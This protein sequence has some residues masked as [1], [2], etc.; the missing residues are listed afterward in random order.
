MGALREITS[1]IVTV[2]NTG[3]QFS[4]SIPIDFNYS[5]L[6][7]VK[8]V[9]L[10]DNSLP[11]SKE[12]YLRY[13]IPGDFV[14]ILSLSKSQKDSKI[15]V[16]LSGTLNSLGR[17]MLVGLLD[18]GKLCF[19]K[20]IDLTTVA[21]L[22]KSFSFA[23]SKC[24]V[25]AKPVV[26]IFK[27]GKD[28]VKLIT[29][30]G[31]GSKSYALSILDE[32]LNAKYSKKG[33]FNDVLSYKYMLYAILGIVVL[34]LLFAVLSLSKRKF[35]SVLALF[36]FIS[37]SVAA[38]A[39]LTQNIGVANPITFSEDAP[40]IKFLVNFLNVNNE[41]GQNDNIVFDLSA[42]DNFSATLQKYPG[43][44]IY[45]SLDG[46]NTEALVMQATDPDPTVTVSLP[47]S[48]S[49]GDHEITFRVPD[50]CG[51]AYDYSSFNNAEFGTKDCIFTTP[52]TV[53]QSATFVNLT[54]NPLAVPQGGTTNLTWYLSSDIVSCTA[55]GAW[56]GAKSTNPV[57]TEVSQNLNLAPHSYD[58]RLSC[59]NDKG[60]S[61]TDNV[62]VV[63]YNCGD[64]VCTFGET[65][66]NCATDCGACATDKFLEIYANPRIV[67][68]GNSTEIIWKSLGYK[69]C[70]VTEDNDSINDY[71]T[72]LAK[73][74]TSSPLISDTT[75]TLT[76]TDGSQTD[77]KSVKV[78]V[79]PSW[80]EY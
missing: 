45:A 26:I 61:Y 25:N 64:G 35:L 52:F 2:Q 76:C 7:D 49:L 70:E 30:A 51:S 28:N 42:L 9:I 38:A 77:S 47:H 58:F 13:T 6:A 14:E 78:R 20:E 44:E 60:E 34:I 29:Y 72:G 55:S 11:V 5:G 53:V 67:K 68:T 50:M 10:D 56:S 22:R 69:S 66:N 37:V 21:P 65:C 62:V 27:G 48:L 18:G 79:A 71:W 32:Y 63:T 24:T 31:V 74:V 19:Q 12:V 75:Y 3:G 41:V 15:E 23:G 36:V 8:L 4:L 40:K 39:T 16:L 80:I 57:N 73:Q 43:T 1:N 59:T 54:A 17:K 33:T 46:G